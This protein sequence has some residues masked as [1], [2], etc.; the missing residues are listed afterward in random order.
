MRNEARVAFQPALNSGMLMRSIVVHHY[1]QLQISS[2]LFIQVFEKLQE[3]LV[4]MASI[5]LTDNFTL[6][7]LKCGKE[8]RGPIPLVIVGHRSAAAFLHRQPRLSAVQGLNL[9]LFIDTEH[10]RFGR[11]VE[12]QPDYIRQLFQKSGIS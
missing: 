1:M 9:A 4:T 10:Q 5:A 12:I 8:R 11:R 7:Y 2:K 6:R 3:L